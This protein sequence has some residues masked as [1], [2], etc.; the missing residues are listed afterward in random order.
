M[1]AV[2]AG[3]AVL[4]FITILVSAIR[5]RRVDRTGPK[6]LRWARPALALAAALLIVFLV[7]LALVLAMG[8]DTLIFKVP[9]MLYV[10]LAFPLLALPF[11]LLA[12]YFLVIAWRSPAWRF[13]TRLHYTLATLATL[14]FLCVLN[15]WNLIGYRFG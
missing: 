10:V 12:L 9:T 6:Q 13:G 5:Q 11:A 15:Y 8:I 2:I 14:A 4:F 1:H 3:L 7:G